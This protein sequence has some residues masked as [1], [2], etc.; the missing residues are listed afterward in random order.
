MGKKEVILD[1]SVDAEEMFVPEIPATQEEP[2]DNKGAISCLKNEK[3]IVRFVP[4]QS[5]MITNPNH[6]NY[7]GMGE[8]SKRVFTVPKLSSTRT[9]KNVLTNEEKAFLEEYMGL[10][11]NDL[12]IYKKHDNYWSGYMVTL[13]KGDTILDLSNP[14]DYIKY[15]VLLANSDY[16]A[17]SLSELQDRPKATYQFVI[18]NPEDEA[19]A[20]T[21]QLS[22][23]Q[24]AYMKFGTLQ[25]NADAL[26]LI[27]E[28][29][30]GRPIAKDTKLEFL[31]GKIG[32]LIIS[33]A[34]LFCSVAEDPYLDVKVLI[35]KAHEAGIIAKRGTFYYLK[36]DNLP[37]CEDR[38]EP[39][40]N[41]AAKYLSSSKHQELKFSI[42]AQ[43]K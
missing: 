21:R 43:L 29:I 26:K 39:T 5:G 2:V 4:R 40:L 38:E 15:K 25:T 1:T 23:N 17:P 22:Y 3:I 16:I 37:L 18:I 35:R 42:E 41:S 6:V 32:E 11:N 10:E 7:G 28:T 8:N 20:S 19:K 34:K 30:D 9:Y 31:Q 24:R 14:E 33:N 27:I 13:T 36:K 12:S